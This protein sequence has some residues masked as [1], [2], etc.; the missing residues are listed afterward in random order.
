MEERCVKTESFLYN[1]PRRSAALRTALHY[2]QRMRRTT[3]PERA[4]TAASSKA[5]RARSSYIN[6][7]HCVSFIFNVRY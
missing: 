5:A 4:Q 7:N 6:L 1:Q 3:P 2:G